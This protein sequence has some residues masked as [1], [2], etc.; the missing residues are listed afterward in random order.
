MATSSRNHNGVKIEILQTLIGVFLTRVNF[1]RR[2]AFYWDGYD[3]T[4]ELSNFKGNLVSHL[5]KLKDMSI[6]LG[7]ENPFWGNGTLVWTPMVPWTL[8]ST[9]LENFWLSILIGVLKF[10]P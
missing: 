10:D 1:C 7:L 9:V 2:K 8:S 6:E 4:S 5:N 3:K